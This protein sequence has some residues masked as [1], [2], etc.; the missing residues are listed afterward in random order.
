MP[1]MAV[2]PANHCPLRIGLPLR[3]EPRQELPVRQFVPSQADPH[4]DADVLVWDV[5]DVG[6]QPHVSGAIQQHHR[7]I[8]RRPAVLGDSGTA[9][10]A[11]PPRCYKA[12]GRGATDASDA[13][14]S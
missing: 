14:R 2:L 10:A 1:M 3:H 13:P 4:A 11:G 7:D 9:G 8:I 12:L 6:H 5:H